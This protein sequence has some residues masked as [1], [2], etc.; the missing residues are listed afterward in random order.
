MT[1][2]KKSGMKQKM[3]RAES[4][5]ASRMTDMMT[6]VLIA[7]PIYRPCCMEISDVQKGGGS[8]PPLVA[9][10]LKNSR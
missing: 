8:R 5:S 6:L 1:S 2:Q 4:V 7:H 3:S 9:Q 10:L